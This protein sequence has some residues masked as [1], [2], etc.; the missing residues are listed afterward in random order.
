[1]SEIVLIDTSVYLNVLDVPGFNQEREKIFAEFRQR[2]EHDAIFLLP[3]A[4]IWETGNHIS[5]LPNGNLRRKYAQIFVDQIGYAIEG[6][7]PY[8]PT[9]FPDQQTFRKW[10]VDYPGYA[11]R[12]KTLRKTTEG[13][14]LS[15]LSIIWEWKQLCQRHPMSRVIIWSLDIDLRHYDSGM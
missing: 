3:L 9:Y 6:K 15:D 7:S 5:R 14:S 4:T 13:G 1:M 2:I 11:Q 10:M 12:N 8:R